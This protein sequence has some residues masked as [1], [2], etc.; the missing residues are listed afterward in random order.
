MYFG[1]TQ[2]LKL[3]NFELVAF[4]LRNCSHCSWYWGAM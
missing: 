3:W 2:Q 1:S 4:G